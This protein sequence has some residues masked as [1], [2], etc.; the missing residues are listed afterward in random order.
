M[1]F[2]DE[3]NPSS[4]EEDVDGTKSD[5]VK[6]FK[7]MKDRLKKNRNYRREKSYQDMQEDNDPNNIRN[8]TN[9]NLLG[10]KS[11]KNVVVDGQIVVTSKLIR[12]PEEDHIKPKEHKNTTLYAV[13][14]S[15]KRWRYTGLGS[16]MNDKQA[17]TNAPVVSL[18]HASEIPKGCLVTLRT[19]VR[20]CLF[21][22]A[23][24]QP[25]S[26]IDTFFWSSCLLC[27]FCFKVYQIE[28]ATPEDANDTAI[29][30]TPDT[31]RPKYHAVELKKVKQI[32]AKSEMTATDTA[33][34]KDHF[35]VSGHNSNTVV[36][37]TT[38]TTTTTTTSNDVDREDLNDGKIYT[39]IGVICS[40]AFVVGS[41]RQLRR[42]H[43]KK[44]ETEQRDT[45]Q[46]DMDQRDMEHRDVGHRD[47]GHR[48]VGHRETYNN[49]GVVAMQYAA[50]ML[51]A[52]MSCSSA[53]EAVAAATLLS[54]G[55]SQ[56]KRKYS[57]NQQPYGVGMIPINGGNG[58]NGGNTTTMMNGRPSSKSRRTT[59]ASSSSSS[60]SSLAVVPQQHQQ[61]QQQ[62]SGQQQ[63]PEQFVQYLY[64]RKLHPH[65]DLNSGGV[66]V[67]VTGTL[68]KMYRQHQ[69]QQQ[70][71]KR[72]FQQQQE[73]LWQQFQQQQ[74]QLHH[75]H[76]Q[77]L[78]QQLRAKQQQVYR[79]RYQRQQ[80]QPPPQQQQPPPQQQQQPQQPQQPQ[81]QQRRRPTQRLQLP[82][83]LQLNL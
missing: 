50:P 35:S 45:E 73:M 12:V 49:G 28:D 65:Q 27:L 17:M 78:Q 9:R 7:K 57:N 25:V 38:I 77:L 8:L 26:F 6:K 18:A 44:A 46:R 30:R 22:F 1:M 72:Q 31:S 20:S 52:G 34:A 53:A 36:T 69:R 51:N 23:C 56:R 71:Y 29:Q 54:T 80:Q 4:V 68:L 67:D 3:L 59:T 63:V 60:S 32:P 62:L 83:H 39:C 66:P 48:D 14:L 58:G 61:Q 21:V 55:G 79:Q 82:Q 64:Q 76:S 16:K 24:T 40:P 5:K 13:V 10:V 81:Q 47:V 33:S 70:L 42:V 43:V 19:L 75:Q 37:V 2:V 74:Q 15:P 11:T 41:T